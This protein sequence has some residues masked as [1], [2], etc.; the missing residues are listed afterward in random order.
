MTYQDSFPTP[1]TASRL[2]DQAAEV[3]DVF[4]QELIAQTDTDNLDNPDDPTRERLHNTSKAMEHI[5][6]S[7]KFLKPAHPPSP[8]QGP[9]VYYYMLQDG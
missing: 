1:A 5:Y 3:L 8:S 6:A 9:N 4:L 7:I 2:L